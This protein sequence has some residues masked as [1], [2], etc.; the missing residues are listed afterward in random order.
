MVTQGWQLVMEAVE[1]EPE[2]HSTHEETFD[3]C[4]NV[5]DFP[6]G[7]ILQASWPVSSSY[8]PSAHIT[9]AVGGT[10]DVS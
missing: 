7:Q 1:I 6:V 5:L 9:Q 8:L 2:P 4:V 3:C 10:L